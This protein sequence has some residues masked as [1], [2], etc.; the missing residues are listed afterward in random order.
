M[1]IGQVIGATTL[2][3]FRFVI[4]EGM[5]E[6]VKRDEFVCVAESVTGRKI[7]GV[8]KD[9][10]V[11]NDL[12]PDEF[13]R[14]LRMSE[15]VF[16]EGEYPV[17]IVKILGIETSHGLTLP[18]HGIKPGT[19]VSLAS[20]E[21]LN[22][23]LYQDPQTS[24]HIGHLSTRES[25]PVNLSLNDLVSRHAS[26][27]AMTGAGKSYT[28]GVLIE[29]LMK[30]KGSIIIF[31]PHGEYSRLELEGSKVKVY[32]EGYAH[33]IRIETSSITAGDYACLIPDL[34]GTQLDLLDEVLDLVA[35]FYQK[36]DLDTILSTLSSIYDLKKNGKKKDSPEHEVF[37]GRHLKSI[38]KKVTLSTIGAL[39]RRL[40]RIQRMDVFSMTG[41]SI[42]DIA[43]PNQLTVINLSETEE[44]VSEVIVSIICRKLFSSRKKYVRD[45]EGVSSPVFIMIEEAHNFAPSASDDGT[46]ISRPILRKIAREGRKFAVGLCVISQRPNKLDS[47]V[48][49][50]CNT[51]VI[52]K[53]VNPSD[54][55]HIRASVEN[56]TEEIVNDLPSLGRGEA[57]IV[58]SAIRMSVPTKIRERTT[59]VGGQDIDVVGQWRRENDAVGHDYKGD[60]EK[61]NTEN[62]H[63]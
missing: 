38:T 53:I 3:S 18:S 48:L 19:Q 24:A 47:D 40:R 45:G 29:E 50:Q 2:R 63:E 46:F 32:G 28:A 56:V 15:L 20:D 16:D 11:S 1:E 26:I 23:I 7:L 54:Q 57:I 13:S 17:P 22:R 39:M 33:K 42:T 9:I 14:D 31:D 34:T 10:V 41:T 52:M 51:Q 4:K 6:Y 49:S 5:E 35:R 21:E 27:L 60:A 36:Y 12:L 61:D 55:D 62:Q 58:G 25:I 44:R 30:K 37:P 43:G 59:H 8:V